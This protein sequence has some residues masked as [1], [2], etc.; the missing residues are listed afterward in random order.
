MVRAGLEAWGQGIYNGFN[1][2]LADPESAFLLIGHASGVECRSLSPGIHLLTNEH[3]L[4]EVTLSDSND[5]FQDGAS[6]TEENLIERCTKILKRHDPL[7]TH[8]FAP[9]KHKG[10]RGTRSSAL[11][12]MGEEKTRLLFADGPP[13]T[14]PFLD[15][16][17]L[18][19][20]LV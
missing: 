8:G 20:S 9:C 16:H 18:M 13:C 4:N 10:N 12:L 1:L 19:G 3:D 2:L 11:L 7:D 14:T 17:D 15:L 5:L 6:P